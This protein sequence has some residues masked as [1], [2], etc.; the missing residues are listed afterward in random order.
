MVLGISILVGLT[1]FLFIFLFSELIYQSRI[2]NTIEKKRNPNEW[3][4]YRLGDKI[5]NAL[6]GKRYPEDVAVKLGIDVDEYVQ[7]CNLT[8]TPIEIKSMIVDYL[9]G[10]I[11]VLIS[12]LLAIFIHFSILFFGSLAGLILISYKKQKVKKKADKM[13]QEVA[14]DFPRFLSLLLT[15]LEVGMNIDTAIFSI[16]QK[17]D[18]IIS[19]EFLESLNEVKLGGTNWQT[20]LINV[21]ERYQLDFFSDLVLDITHA[22]NKG[23]SVTEAVRMRMKDSKDKRLFQI[24]ERA[25]RT[26]NAVLIP[27]ALFQFVPIIVFIMLPTVSSINLL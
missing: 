7:N 16:S 8:R 3:L 10:I 6:F 12:I 14:T 15:E 4:F 21:T 13:R 26:E 2:K 5:Y 1:I 22:Y 25:A 24:K 17:F 11:V 20:A 23:V 27:I 18:S 19:R 9:Y